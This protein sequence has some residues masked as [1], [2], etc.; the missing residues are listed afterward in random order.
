MPVAVIVGSP[1][2]IFPLIEHSGCK[3][4]PLTDLATNII[5][6]YQFFNERPNFENELHKWNF[7]EIA[8]K[9]RFPK[10]RQW[11]M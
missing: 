6:D 1:G 5:G 10:H 4:D 8:E 11:L 7:D 3:V 2:P 9:N